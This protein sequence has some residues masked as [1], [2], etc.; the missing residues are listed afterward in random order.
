MPRRKLEFFQIIEAVQVGKDGL[1][2]RLYQVE[3][4]SVQGPDA[5]HGA[6]SVAQNKIILPKK[7]RG[8]KIIVRYTT[9]H[10]RE[11]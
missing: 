4:V 9:A 5:P 6:F 1:N 11:F 2:R 7:M 10:Q 3:A 8:E